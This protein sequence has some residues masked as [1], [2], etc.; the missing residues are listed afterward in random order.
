MELK[1][2]AFNIPIKSYKREG[3]VT[4][5]NWSSINKTG[6]KFVQDL[7]ELNKGKHMLAKEMNCVY[8]V[9]I[10]T[11]PYQARLEK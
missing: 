8:I 9:Y 7:L 5:K 1:D 6:K 2:Y 3:W 11:G 4:K 10:Y